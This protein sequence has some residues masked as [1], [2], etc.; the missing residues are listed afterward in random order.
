MRIDDDARVYLWW[1]AVL[2]V[3]PTGSTVTIEVDGVAYPMAWQGT[4]VAAAGQWSQTAR[5]VDM[6]T[7]SA[8]TPAGT[9]VALPA[10]RHTAQPR[11]TLPDG[12]IIPSTY[13]DPLDID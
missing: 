12:Q 11:V 1:D 3:D 7:G 13:P 9:D 6:F 5:T 4:P 8:V 10:G 2:T